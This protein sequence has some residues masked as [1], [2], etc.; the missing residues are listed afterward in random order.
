MSDT[1][2]LPSHIPGTFRDFQRSKRR[3]WKAVLAALD[4][5]AY[6]SAYTP[7]GAYKALGSMAPLLAEISR[8]LKEWK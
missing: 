8:Q 3:E 1:R 6:A 2:R 4:T 7:P 5:Y